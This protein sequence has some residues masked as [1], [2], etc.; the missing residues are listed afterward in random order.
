MTNERHTTTEEPRLRDRLR[1]DLN[2][3]G[4]LDRLRRDLDDIREFYVTEEK[5]SRLSAM[6]WYRRWATLIFWLL[7]SM[8]LKLTPARRLLVIAGS[9]L[10]LTD[11]VVINTGSTTVST[12]WDSIGWVLL[13]IV[14]ML[15]LKDRILARS[16]LAEGRG[17][18]RALMPEAFPAFA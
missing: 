5:R 10:I 16:E 7:K 9:V 17:V 4:V 14:L 8:L 18:Q 15:E 13:I 1:D 6:P 12:N 3:T 2:E 11:G